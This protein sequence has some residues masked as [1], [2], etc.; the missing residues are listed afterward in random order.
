MEKSTSRS[1]NLGGSKSKLF[2]ATLTRDNR[3]IVGKLRPH[4]KFPYTVFYIVELKL[5][6]SFSRLSSTE[7]VSN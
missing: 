2:H 4:Q 1:N 6:S 3:I 5:K 7:F